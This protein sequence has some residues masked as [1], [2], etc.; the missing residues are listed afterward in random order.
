[1][2]GNN[3]T[4]LH[5]LQ[6]RPPL[7]PNARKAN[8]RRD[9]QRCPMTGVS[10]P[11][12][13]ELR[14][15]GEAQCFRAAGQRGSSPRTRP[16]PASS[17]STLM[18][19]EAALWIVCNPHHLN[20]FDIYENPFG[21]KPSIPGGAPLKAR[22]LSPFTTSSISSSAAQSR[23]ADSFL[24]LQT[25]QQIEMLNSIS[26][27]RASPQTEHA[28]TRF[29]EYMKREVTRGFYTSPTGLKEIDYKGNAFY[30]RSPG[31]GAC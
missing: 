22:K 30:A 9:D 8:P 26:D 4:G 5:D 21:S 2:P 15:N 20:E 14:S 18:S 3:R 29:F 6:R 11:S 27:G 16:R 17:R 23:H 31:C 1:M 12:V 10:L 28:G 13:E 24:A 19:N 25:A 7:R